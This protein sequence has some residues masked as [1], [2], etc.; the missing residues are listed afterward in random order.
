M[1]SEHDGL[2][3]LARIIARVHMKRM[4]NK[5]I[6][7]DS[8][9]HNRKQVIIAQKRPINIKSDGELVDEETDRI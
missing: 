1:E 9:L 4:S 8:H 7:E 5:R 2:H 3:V 6:N